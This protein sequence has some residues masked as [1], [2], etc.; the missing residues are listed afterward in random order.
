MNDT[1]YDYY[2]GNE[3]EQFTF[4]RIPKLLM[5]E[6]RFRELSIEA[7]MLYGL[8]MDR[9]SLSIRNKW[10]DEE[11][12]VYIIYTFDEIMDDFSFGRQKVAKLLS[13]LDDFNLIERKRRG[14]GKPN[15]IYVKNIV[16]VMKS[17]EYENQTSGSMKTE[18][19]EV[20]KSNFKKYENQTSRS[21]NSILQEVPKSNSNDNKYNNTDFNDTECSD[22]YP[23]QSYHKPNITQGEKSDVMDEIE[24]YSKYREVIKDNIEYDILIE[25]YSKEAI[26]GIVELMTETVC[27]KNDYITVSGNNMPRDVV[28]SRLLKLNSSHIEYVMDCMRKSTTKIRNIKQYLI[29]ALYNSYTT[30][31]HY[32][33]AEVNYDM[34]GGESI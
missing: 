34:H 26:E 25:R 15:I 1:R 33:T 6:E 27:T 31:D 30:I 4:Y 9:M 24:S 11:N 22:T 32:Y 29:S 14:Q 12:R 28:K 17:E 7:K 8:L 21:M 23:I 13:E 10:L 3:A 19:Q 20:P 16:A 2:Y 5:K 18:L